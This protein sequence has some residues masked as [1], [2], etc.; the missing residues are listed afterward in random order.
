ML[1]T[2]VKTF[3]RAQLGDVRRKTK[4]ALLEIAAFGMVGLSVVFLFSG[5][6]LWLS[7]RMEPWLA[8]IVLAGLALLAAMMLI[9]AGHSLLKRQETG[10]Y[11]QA[12]SALKASGLLSQ[13]GPAGSKENDGKQEPGPAMVASALAAGVILGR[14]VNR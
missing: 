7:T 1:E 2:L 11:E 6:F 9:I 4:G 12:M 14:S 3:L 8:A 10:P 13:D 5:L